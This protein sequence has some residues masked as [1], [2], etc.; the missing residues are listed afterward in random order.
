LTCIIGFADRKN[1]VSWIGGDSLGSN[2]YTKAVEMPSKVFRN[3]TFDN[4]LIGGTTTF[5]HLDLLKYSDSLFDEVDLLKKTEIDHRFMVTKFI[6]RVIALFKDGV[7]H[8]GE[9]DRGGNFIVATPGKV[10]E[11]QGDYSVLE[12]ELGICAVGCGEKVAMGSLLTTKDLDMPPEE[13]ILKALEA[14]EQYCCGVQRPFRILCT[15]G[16][17]EI[18]IK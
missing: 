2:G 10:F 8:E 12:P 13:K 4:V 18:I 14:A 7:V 6:P 17:D 15:D 3:N 9:K 11:V 5:R 16:R 1:G